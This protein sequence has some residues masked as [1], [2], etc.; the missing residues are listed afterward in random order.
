VNPVEEGLTVQDHSKRI[1][2][3]L[4]QPKDRP[5]FKLE[6]VV[7]GTNIRRSRSAKT[8]DPDQAER[9]RSDLEYEL[10]HGLH[11]DPCKMPFED[12]RELYEDERLAE[13]RAATRK[14]AG[15]VFDSFTELAGPRT[16]GDVDA[17]MLSGYARDLR[18][19]GRSPATLQAHLAYLRAA[20]RWAVDQGFLPA[21]PKVAM[22][23]VP[24]KRHINRIDRPQFERLLQEAPND[25][26][27]LF[28][29]TA[30]YTGMRRCELLALTWDGANGMP[31][32][33][34]GRR[35]IWIPAAHNK[36]GEDQCLPIHP[37]LLAVYKKHLGD[38]YDL[39]EKFATVKAAP[40]GRLYFLSASPREVS[41]KFTALA[42]R[43]GLNITLHDLRRSF[44]SRYASKVTAPQLKA[45]MRHADIKTTLEF[46]ADVSDT[47]DEAITQ[48]G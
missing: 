9:L 32:V 31:W 27:R 30:W 45:L 33:D 34:L 37:A 18:K 29:W 7:P 16:L 22:P 12:F 20:L 47:L 14:K 6:W 46:Y 48:V 28:L 36:S 17:R 13:K 41:R 19:L 21:V 5:F 40:R 24:K 2:V 15:Y 38:G 11:R 3:Y 23:K 8:A 35:R 10:N 4:L 25:G 26:W 1:T 44:G 39:Y 42:K 43:A